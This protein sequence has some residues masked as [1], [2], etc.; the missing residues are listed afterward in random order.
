MHTALLGSHRSR[1]RR[2]RLLGVVI[3][4]VA[5]TPVLQAPAHAAP[6]RDVSASLA[7]V[8]H[9][10]RASGVDGIAWYVDRSAD[11]VVVTTDDTVSRAEVA[12]IVKFARA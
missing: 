6:R 12:S 4:A 9:D 7:D 11:K 1:R 2:L 10:V 5:S 3:V 8:R